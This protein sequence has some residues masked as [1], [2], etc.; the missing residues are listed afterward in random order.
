M[1]KK[2]L[3]YLK[4]KSKALGIILLI[5]VT[6]SYLFTMF[7]NESIRNRF[8][9]L[10][11][12][13]YQNFWIENDQNVYA[14]GNQKEK[15]IF[16]KPILKQVLVSMEFPA[17]VEATKELQ[18]Q[19]KQSG[20][21]QKIHVTE[22]QSVKKGQL[23]VELDDELLRLEG[24]KLSISLE[25]TKANQVISFQKW[26]QAEKLIE[27]KVREIDKKTEMLEI[28]ESEW[29]MAKDIKE[30]KEILWKQG[31]ISLSELD[32]WKF[33]EE[34]KHA[35]Y[36]NIKRDRDSLLSVLNLNF[37]LEEPNLPT[38]LKLW[39]EQNTIIERTEYE[40]SLTNTKILENQIKFNKQMISESK[41]FAPKAGTI[42]KVHLKEGEISNHLTLLSL[43]ENGDL[44][45]LFQIGESDL[46]LIQPGKRVEFKPS[47]DGMPVAFGKI[48]TVSGYLESRTHGIG[49]KVKLFKNQHSLMTGMFGVAKVDTDTSKDLLLVPKESVFGDGAS[50][51]FLFL[52]KGETIQKR[53]IQCKSYNERDMEV[54]SGLNSEDLFQVN[55]K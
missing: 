35:I 10:S 12:V 45:V 19:S 42:L 41:L 25:V 6:L 28:A 22:G 7:S 18:L 4:S 44:S 27:V 48:D 14:I 3:S 34:N 37:D 31:Y 30:K 54:V 24:E 26:K 21:I 16:S 50:G 20:R 29:E 11:Y 1:K 23:L 49:V 17:T 9:S 46:K 32:K 47:L 8:R 15:P 55:V 13:M 36:K 53:F 2:F 43:I 51:F 5:Y 38:K 40:L 33:D 52:K 39:K